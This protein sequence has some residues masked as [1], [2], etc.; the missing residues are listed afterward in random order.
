M[1]AEV[2]GTRQTGAVDEGL[3]EIGVLAIESTHVVNIKLEEVWGPDGEKAWIEGM[4]MGLKRRSAPEANSARLMKA[5]LLTRERMTAV[6]IIVLMKSPGSLQPVLRVP[7]VVSEA[8]CHTDGKDESQR[9]KPE[10]MQFPWPLQLG[11]GC[12]T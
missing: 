2:E 12:L 9:G 3:L 4:G 6:L 5:V 1:R 8:S 10:P 11:H 7:P